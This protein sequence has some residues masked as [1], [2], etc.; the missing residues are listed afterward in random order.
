MKA[1]QQVQRLRR[2]MITHY[3]YICQVCYYHECM[4]IN[5]SRNY[6]MTAR[7]T[8]TTE[9][10]FAVSTAAP[11]IQLTCIEAENSRMSVDENFSDATTYQHSCLVR[12]SLFCIEL[13]NTDSYSS[14]ARYVRA[15]LPYLLLRAELL[16]SPSLV[17]QNDEENPAAT[18][19]ASACSFTEV[20]K[21]SLRQSPT[22]VFKRSLIRSL[23]CTYAQINIL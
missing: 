8:K 6:S 9:P 4:L 3:C 18:D 17:T 1:W 12:V 16:S 13:I 23:C 20:G 15:H 19:T 5:L 10:Q 14:D 21:G 7:A 22:P 2:K 11:C